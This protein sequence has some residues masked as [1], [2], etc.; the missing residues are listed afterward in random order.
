MVQIY[1]FFKIQTNNPAIF[2]KIQTN[3]LAIFDKIQTN[4]PAIFDKIQTNNREPGGDGPRFGHHLL[5][6]QRT[7]TGGIKL[8]LICREIRRVEGMERSGV[9]FE[10][11]FLRHKKRLCRFPVFTYQR[12]I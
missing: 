12:E 6:Q 7:D 3:N 9:I 1:K 2:N 11:I 4:N 5:G 10:W 8:Y